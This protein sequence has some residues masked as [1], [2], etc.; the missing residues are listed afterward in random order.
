MNIRIREARPEDAFQIAQINIGSWHSTYRGLIADATLDGMK[1]EDYLKKWNT[2]FS[3]LEENGGFCF[4]ADD[5]VHH[6]IGYSLCGKNRHNQ[7]PFESELYAIYL[8][9]EYQGK[10][11]G[12]KLFLK[13]VEEFRR[14]G[15][16]SFLL[17]VLSSN[18]QS[19][20]FYESFNPDFSA[21]E[22]III[23]NGQYCDFCYGWS[24]IMNIILPVRNV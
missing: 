18:L 8:L 5:E 14:R 10:G 21:E 20:K 22:T 24:D 4:V 19:R 7:F 13:S 6:V 3:V 11:I 12:K 1:F 16:A 17:F 15:N 9:E 2:T 23:D